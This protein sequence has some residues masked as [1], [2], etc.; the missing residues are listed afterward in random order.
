MRSLCS[1]ANCELIPTPCVLYHYLVVFCMPFRNELSS[2]RLRSAGIMFRYSS[3]VTMVLSTRIDS[4][5]WDRLRMLIGEL[6]ALRR[7]LERSL[8]SWQ[9]SSVVSDASIFDIASMVYYICSET[10]LSLSTVLPPCEFL[11]T[12][13]YESGSVACYNSSSSIRD[14]F[15]DSAYGAWAF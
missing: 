14:G 12:L 5:I 6:P 7:A 2:T 9:I 13:F 10:I 11:L 1:E 3:S 4:T 8:L 15:V